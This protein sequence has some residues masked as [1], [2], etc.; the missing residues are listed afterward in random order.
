MRLKRSY[1]LYIPYPGN[2]FNGERRLRLI[3]RLPLSRAIR[4]FEDKHS[5]ISCKISPTVQQPPL[6]SSGKPTKVDLSIDSHAVPSAS[7]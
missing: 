1:R 7:S 2:F 4:S 6:N 3:M 5:G